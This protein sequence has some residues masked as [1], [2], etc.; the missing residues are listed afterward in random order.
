MLDI[1]ATASCTNAWMHQD[2]T[3][4]LML[5]EGMAAGLGRFVDLKWNAGAFNDLVCGVYAGI[6][7]NSG[8][9]RSKGCPFEFNGR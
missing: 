2:S 8:H 4:P 9:H 6:A 3:Q 7:A 5:Q 1:D